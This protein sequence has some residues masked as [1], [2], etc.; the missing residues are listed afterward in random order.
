[1]AAFQEYEQAHEGSVLPDV[2]LHSRSRLRQ[3]F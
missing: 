1:M 2:T 3:C